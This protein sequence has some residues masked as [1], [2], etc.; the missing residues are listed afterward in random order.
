MQQYHD[1]QTLT[2]TVLRLI[3]ADPCKAKSNV[4]RYRCMSKSLRVTGQGQ[5]KTA[6]RGP[7]SNPRPPID[8]IEVPTSK[9]CHFGF[10]SR[11]GL[12]HFSGFGPLFALIPSQD[13]LR[14][15]Q[16]RPKTANRGHKNGLRPPTQA[17]QLHDRPSIENVEDKVQ[18][19]YML[20][21]NFST[22][23]PSTV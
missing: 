7:K 15:P 13:R 3:I 10:L 9:N 5:P 12:G 20:P 11:S 17:H 18:R 14:R 1:E 8:S 23:H 16:E 19:L 6:H 22:D 21:V 2:R 4:F